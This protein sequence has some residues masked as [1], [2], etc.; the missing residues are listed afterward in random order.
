MLKSLLPILAA[1]FLAACAQKTEPIPREGEEPIIQ[2]T[3]DV[4]MN[5]AEDD[6]EG[7]RR[8]AL[9]ALRGYRAGIARPDPDAP[10]ASSAY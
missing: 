7:A 9:R 3:S 10:P 5:L 8:A 6:G 2:A 4:L 1:V